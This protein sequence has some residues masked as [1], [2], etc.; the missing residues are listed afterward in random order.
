MAGFGCG[1]LALVVRWLRRRGASGVGFVA[2]WAVYAPIRDCAVARTT[3]LIEFRYQ[4]W[5]VVVAADSLSGVVIPILVAY[6]A[7]VL[8]AGRLPK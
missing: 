8:I 4:P 3:G 5:P 1:A 7:I 2:F 6:G